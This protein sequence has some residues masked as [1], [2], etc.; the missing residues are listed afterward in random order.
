MDFIKSESEK[1]MPEFDIRQK[2]NPDFRLFANKYGMLFP[3]LIEYNPEQVNDLKALLDTTR[4]VPY[5]EATI[6]G[7]LGIA[8]GTI[9]SAVLLAQS[10][11]VRMMHVD[12]PC[13]AF[14]PPKKDPLNA[15]VEAFDKLLG[16]SDHLVRSLA[17]P[18][19][20]TPEQLVSG[21]LQPPSLPALPFMP[22]FPPLPFTDS[23]L[24]PNQQGQHPVPAGLRKDYFSTVDTRKMIGADLADAEGITG[25]G[26]TIAILDT[27]LDQFHPQVNFG[28]RAESTMAQPPPDENGHGTHCFTTAIGKEMTNLY[29]IPL[30]GVAP[31]ATGIAIKCL[32]GGV[33]A[34]R[35]SDILKAIELAVTLKADVLSM[36]LG[37]QDAE[38]GLGNDPLVRAVNAATK[39]GKI[40]VI[41]AGNCLTGDSLVSTNPHGAIPIKN[42]KEGMSVY[43]FEGKFTTQQT[44]GKHK[45][46]KQVFSAKPVKHKILRVLQNGTQPIYEIKTRTRTIKATANHPLLTITR[47]LQSKTIGKP[48]N[49]LRY[50]YELRWKTV[51]ELTNNDVIVINKKLPDCE[52]PISSYSEEF[53]Q[54]IGCFIGDGYLRIRETGNSVH[55]S[56]PITGKKI[57]RDKYIQLLRQEF[58]I[59]PSIIDKN[60]VSL[61]SKKIAQ[62]F[63]DLGLNHKA[64]EKTIPEWI[65]SLPHNLKC[66]FLQGYIDSDGSK[67]KDGNVAFESPN[68]VLIQ[69]I[70]MLCIDV[71][72]HVTN[73]YH[74][75]RKEHTIFNG[76]KTYSYNNYQSYCFRLTNFSNNWNRTFSGNKLSNFRFNNEYFGIEYILAINLLGSEP[77][78][79]IEVENAHNFIANGIVVHNS[80][81]KPET[82]GCPGCAPDALTVG[83]IDPRDDKIAKFSSRGP[84]YGL[85]KPDVVSYGVDIYSGTSKG[86]VLDGINDRLTDGFAILSGSSM[87]TP[88]VAGLCALLKQKFPELTTEKIK[89]VCEQKGQR[90]DNTYGYGKIH[91]SWFT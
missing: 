7:F 61:Y 34:G 1:I 33:G 14:Q 50:N 12:Y 83:A 2:F 84:R 60:E 36:S 64:L 6:L 9:N 11:A 38:G 45:Y 27:G 10:P 20:P 58:Q 51:A 62:Q 82:I 5:N 42:L 13:F 43:A 52:L 71:G 87:S 59:E 23:G 46:P 80:G 19:I 24:A 30:K 16:S 21:V 3:L 90:K 78:Y 88:H 39:L 73:I 65:L 56:L 54:I 44:I 28:S 77:V 67:Q 72:F 22:P 55:F 25:Q 29:N 41:A 74:R 37:S 26:V 31:H 35:T 70:R 18:Q 85:T 66:S 40:C 57:I 47:A 89:A 53:M 86:S 69:Q 76:K 15:P 4:L 8:A 75:V 49:R 81:D 63:I 32:G 91:Y 48:K 68:E 17:L 79:D